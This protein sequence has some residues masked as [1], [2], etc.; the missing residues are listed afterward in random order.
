MRPLSIAT[1]VRGF[2]AYVHVMA[3]HI[4]VLYA[5]PPAFNGK[6]ILPINNPI[7]YGSPA[8]NQDKSF[9]DLLS[10]GTIAT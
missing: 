6:F 8:T 7:V 4:R 5:I 1:I 2:F 10:Y 9:N 3:T